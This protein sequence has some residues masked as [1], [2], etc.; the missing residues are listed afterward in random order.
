MPQNRVP[1]GGSALSSVPRPQSSLV[2]FW[3]AVGIAVVLVGDSLIQGDLTFVARSAPLAALGV[4]V[5]WVILYRPRIAFGAERVVV[6]NPG[7]VID[8]PW[9]RAS[10]VRQKLQIVIEL[11]DGSSVTCWGSPF[12]DKPGRVRPTAATRRAA[13]VAAPLEAARAAAGGGAA[14][15]PVSRRWDTPALVIGGVLVVASILAIA[16]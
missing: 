13:D 4:W 10:A 7:R 8:I 2:A 11:D 16:L 15:R 12:P 14:D 1:Q 5:L 9:A 6:H 3:A